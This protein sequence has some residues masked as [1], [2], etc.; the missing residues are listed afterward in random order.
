MFKKSI[1]NF[2]GPY[3]KSEP[4][5]KIFP[6]T[7]NDEFILMGSDG[8]WDYM[9]SKEAAEIIQSKANSSTEEIKNCI[10]SNL[11]EKISKK[12][13][14]PIEKIMSM[15]NGP[16]KRSKHDDITFIL[17]RQYL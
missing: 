17:F 13:K 8:L 7:P 6:I 3:I 1:P 16:Q 15:P 2:H 11:M 14:I 12:N 10:F 5:I 9:S 4:E